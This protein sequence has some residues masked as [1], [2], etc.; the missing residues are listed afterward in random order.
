MISRYSRSNQKI[1]RYIKTLVKQ[2]QLYRNFTTCTIKSSKNKILN[3]IEQQPQHSLKQEQ[4]ELKLNNTNRDFRIISSNN[5]YNRFYSTQNKNSGHILIEDIETVGTSLLPVINKLQ[6]TTALIGSEITLPQIIVI[7][8]QSS[9]KSSVLENLVGRDFLPRGSGLVTR[10]PLILQLNKHDSLEEYGEF[11]HTGNKKFDFDGIKQEIERETERLAGAN[12]DISSEPILLRIY[13]PNVIP[14]TLVDTPGI[15]RVP[16]GDQ[17]SNIEEK[18]KS[19]IMEYISNPNSIILAITSANQDIVTSDGIKLAKEVDPEG[20]RTIGVLT[21]LDLMDKGT[22]AIDVLLGDQIPLKYGFV[23]I[24]NRSQQDINNRKPISQMLKDEQ[25]WFDQHPA[26]SRINNQLGTKYLAQKCNKILTKHIR[27]TFPSVKNQIRQLI[28]KYQDEL[29]KYGEP[30]PERSVD[31]SR[32]LIDILNRFS[33]QFRSDLDGSNEELNTKHFNGGARI[34]A[35]FTQSFKQVQEQSPF[36]WISDKQLRVALRNAAG[37]R[38]TM[39]IPQKTFD[40]LVKKQIEKLKDPATQ[41]SDLVLDELLRILTQVDSHILSRFPVLRD[42]IVEVSNNVLRK[43]LSPTNK[44]ISDMVDA[45][46]CFINTSHPVYLGELNK[47]LSGSSPNINININAT[48]TPSKSSNTSYGDELNPY[49]IDRSY[50]NDDYTQKQQQQQQQ[51][52][53]QQS[54]GILRRIFGT[55]QPQQQVQPQQQQQVQQIKIQG[56][57][58]Q[59]PKPTIEYEITEELTEDEKKQIVLLKR[60]LLSYYNIAQFNVQENTMKIIT[61]FLIERSKD[62]LQRELATQLYD[63]H[64]VDQL[65]R[66]NENI[67]TRRNECIYKLD[68]LKKAKKSLSMTELKD[69]PLQFY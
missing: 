65:L 7:G 33:N 9:G 19:M 67:I 62:I 60:L 27:D 31:K 39:F 1:T 29:E 24:I 44:M 25:I 43:L 58:T 2:Q 30:I 17:P 10:R 68:I 13:S 52:N 47:L 51:Q 61:L 42:R 36:D 4:Q 59:K 48:T 28:K 49:M 18:L 5:Q 41:C 6:E 26:Y 21:K 35:I 50:P 54:T 23:G 32:L 55:S 14:L 11:A 40:S 15:A 64:L 12:K 63:E 66:E 3:I 57:V 16:I 53:Q 34:R 22:D 38:P 37:I 56:P 8:S 46:A 69:I 45:E 20:K